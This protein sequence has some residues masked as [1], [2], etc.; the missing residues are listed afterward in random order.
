M[1][2]LLILSLAMSV[3]M[4]AIAQTQMPVYRDRSGSFQGA[5]GVV[6]LN[7]DGTPTTGTGGNSEQTQGT[8]PNGG[9]PTGNPNL[10]AGSDG[11]NVRTILTG[12][13]GALRLSLGGTG[14][15]SGGQSSADALS[16]AS[17]GID[18]RSNL[19]LFN[20]VSWDRQRSASAVSNTSGLGLAGSSILG[21][22][23]SR[24]AYA[25]GNYGTVAMSAAGFL[26]TTSFD[27]FAAND[28]YGN[29]FMGLAQGTGAGLPAMPVTGNY[30]YGSNGD[31]WDRMRAAKAANASDGTGLLGVGTL[32]IASGAAPAATTAGNYKSQWLGLSGQTVV[33]AGGALGPTTASN[34]SSVLP[35]A[36][37]SLRP[38]AVADFMHDP[39]LN[40]LIGVRGDA[41]GGLWTQEKERSQFFSEPVGALAANATYTGTTRDGGASPSQWG[42]FSCFVTSDTAGAVRLD[43]STDN[44]NWYVKI[45]ATVVAQTAIRVTDR[46]DSRYSRCRLVNG[47]TANTA[48]PVLT[49]SFGQ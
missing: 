35:D 47:A 33:A 22:Y 32:G 15:A 48:V 9:T 18:T 25:L 5:S 4:P 27:T 39:A 26:H 2:R 10:I 24:P 40:I 8:A 36:N 44:V 14:L 12:P 7:A 42:T 16:A 21:Q 34:G 31:S 23:G 49:S 13:N 6:V 30:I 29:G 46:N 17:T 3:A 20:G 11:T 19:F 1:K 37:G 45:N 41:T 28:G 43:G 38:L